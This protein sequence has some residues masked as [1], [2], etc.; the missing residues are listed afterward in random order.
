MPRPTAPALATLGATALLAIPAAAQ[1]R[2][3]Q[4]LV[5]YDS[6]DA[7]SLAVA[8]HY[9]GSANVPGGA[10]GLPG[11]HPTVRVY[12]LNDSGQPRALSGGIPYA[13]FIT[14]IRDPLRAH[15]TAT[16]PEGTIRCLVMTKGL[17]HRIADTD[18]GNVGDNPGAWVNEF[19]AGDATAA[20]VCGELSLIWQDL[21]AGENGGPADSHADG[22]VQ[23]PLWRA[24]RPATTY[25]NLHARSMNK[26]WVP[27]IGTGQGWTTFIT[28]ALPPERQ[29]LQGD[30]MLV[31][32]LDADTVADVI[33][34]IDRA[35][36]IVVNVDTTAFILDESGS[37]AVADPFANTELD[38]L[39]PDQTRFSD[40][41]ESTRDRLIADG[42]FNPARIRYNAAS[43]D[44][45]FTVGPNVNYSGQGL[46]VSDPVLVLA[47]FGA[48]HAG[49]KPGGTAGTTY[50]ESFNYANGAM[51]ITMESFNGRGFGGLGDLNQE[52][53]ADFIGAGGC[54]AICNVWEPFANFT[55][56]VE[57]AVR[58]FYLG[59]MSWVEAAYTAIPC[60]S[61]QQMVVGDPLARVVRS[62]EDVDGNGRIDIDDLY[63]WNQNKTDLNRDSVIDARDLA[64]I[65]AAVRDWD[66]YQ[67]GR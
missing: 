2:P 17:P 46:V 30:I 37:N 40:D 52:Q 49:A 7:S 65:E 1:L 27:A 6:R 16:D 28:T 53:A 63:A 23:N 15:L 22:F 24:T 11:V 43:G 42:R 41:Y 33:A 39:S 54:F 38:N 64:I 4:V 29:L 13:D 5:V 62:H 14:R 19:N 18:N 34:S 26:L 56:D 60:I 35:Q 10:G 9:A 20:S 25:T 55:P 44:A 12:N 58:A 3:E 8:E 31:S 45:N 67:E 48:N 50:A 36:N 61:W 32:T 47:H 59:R 21:S 57:L 51:F 66:G